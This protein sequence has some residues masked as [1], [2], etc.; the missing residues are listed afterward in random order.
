M[1]S[2]K[3]PAVP[4]D[5][6]A[7]PGPNPGRAGATSVPLLQ[8]TRV[9]PDAFQ[10][11]FLLPEDMSSKELD[12]RVRENPTVD[13]CLRIATY[14]INNNGKRCFD[15]KHGQKV[16]KGAPRLYQMIGRKLGRGTFRRMVASSSQQYKFVE[17]CWIANMHTVLLNQDFDPVNY[18][19]VLFR[20]IQK[21]KIWFL[22]FMFSGHLK[23]YRKN[24]RRRQAFVPSN[25]ER[26]LQ[27]LKNI[28]GWMQYA[29]TSDMKAENDLPPPIPFWIGWKSQTSTMDLPWFGG[30]LHQ[31]FGCLH[32]DL[33]RL[34]VTNLC[35]IRT[36]GRALPCPT[37][38]M[39]ESAFKKQ[40]GILTTRVNLKKEVLDVVKVFSRKLGEKLGMSDMPRHTHISVS[41][42]GCFEN[43]Q[44]DLGL[45]GWASDLVKPLEFGI[46]KFYVD[47]GDDVREPL[48]SYIHSSQKGGA[49]DLVDC[50]GE[51]IFPRPVSF[52]RMS[53]AIRSTIKKERTLLSLL[54][55][56]AGLSARQNLT[57]KTLQTERSFPSELGKIVLLLSTSEA[58][59]QGHF[60][61]PFD[62]REV[63]PSG[64][65]IGNGVRLPFWKSS[66]LRFNLRYIP[67]EMPKTRLDCLSEPGAKTRPLGKNQGW[68]TIVNKVMRFMTEP[69]LARDGRA[70]I[71]LRSTNKMWSFLKYIKKRGVAY[72]DPVCQSTDLESAT[73]HIPLDLIESIWSGFTSDVPK[74]HP[75]WVY[76]NLIVSQRSL[77]KS[78]KYRKFDTEYP[79]GMLNQ[80]GSFMGEPMSF[81]TLTLVNLLAEEISSHYYVNNRKLWSPLSPGLEL[82]GD[83]VCICGDDFTAVRDSVKR[84][85]TFKKVMT[86]MNGRFSW[87]DAVSR[88]IMIFCEDHAVLT[89]T[90]ETFSLEYVDVIKSRLLTTMTR[91][92]SENRSS[93]LGKGRMLSNQLDYFSNKSLKIAIFCYFN[94]I[95]DRCYSYGIFRN[96]IRLPIFLPPCAGGMGL[97][98]HEDLMPS[99]MW[100]YIGHVFKS[101]EISDFIDRYVE[102]Q[103]MSALNSRVKHG[104]SV[105]DKNILRIEVGRYLKQGKDGANLIYDDSYIIGLLRDLGV[106]EFVDPYER[107]FDWASLVNEAS[108]IGYVPFDSLSE[109][110]ERVMNFIKLIFDG[111]TKDPRTF[112]KWVRSSK[113]FW[114]SRVTRGNTSE[115]SLVGRERF[116]TFIDLEK[117]IKRSFSG[118]IYTGPTDS[119]F[120]LINSGPSLKINFRDGQVSDLK[121]KLLLYT[122]EVV[123]LPGHR[124]EAP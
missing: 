57:M 62:D 120:N 99:F 122:R 6:V 124:V 64:Y 105:Q 111:S 13:L 112:N 96:Q 41:T 34:E 52:Y 53:G 95:F 20:S 59:K 115:L 78:P 100:P 11:R 22:R 74:G 50:Y 19:K 33:N 16:V 25:F 44:K 94:N 23:T 89:G 60:V 104:I 24:G 88:V 49:V 1:D 5:R 69:I 61:K 29:A 3:N 86:D 30:H 85:R 117:K 77:F 90:G 2:L 63:P 40:M 46:S 14:A 75:F 12:K 43:S 84:V 121:R 26:G 45:S 56:G 98:I 87:K 110:I 107:K 66:L 68:F 79:D 18:D 97:P 92:H 116:T 113:R 76:Y 4:R 71:G 81:L 32:R 15:P 9:L 123:D 72:S 7:S 27:A 28:A 36:F 114:R 38:K 35:Q 83:P 82:T 58:L 47:L 80:N 42:S 73:D 106:N 21:Y 103:S 55:G 10:R 119:Q 31:Y 93:I 67:V 17:E 39:C 65:I 102:I 54:Y 118:W 37:Q 91:Q 48:T 70:R 51:Y 8:D 108:R 101:L 109:E